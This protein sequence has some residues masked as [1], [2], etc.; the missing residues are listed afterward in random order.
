MTTIKTVT[1]F[2]TGELKIA[3]V[4]SP[5]CRKKPK[6]AALTSEAVL[7]VL[8]VGSVTVLGAFPRFMTLHR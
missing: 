5:S 6:W 7:V 3:R 1:V 2:P 4:T 8:V